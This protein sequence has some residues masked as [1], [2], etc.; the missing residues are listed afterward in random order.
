[1]SRKVLMIGLHFPP[2]GLR[3]GYARMMGFA[4]HL[5][6]F[7]WE[8]LILTA[9]PRAYRS[10]DPGSVG[11]IPGGC[12]V[13][14]AFA[15]DARRHLGIGGKYLSVCARPDSWISWWPAAV[16]CGLR[17]IRKHRIQAIWST[18]PVMTAHCVAHT[19]NRLT[20]LPW[21]AD[22][23]DPVA[24]SVAQRDARTIAMQMQWERRTL[25]RAACSVFTT[26]GTMR[27]YAEHYP[28]LADAGR[29]VVIENGFDEADFVGLPLHAPSTQTQPL[30]LVHAGGLYPE[31]R[32]PI[33]LFEAIAILRDEGTIRTDELR[34]T[35]RGSGAD[36]QYAP[37]LARLNLTGIVK[38]APTLPYGEALAEQA[39][40][41]GLLLF[42]GALFDRQIPSKV[43]EYFRLRRPM[44]AMVGEHGDTAALLRDMP[45]TFI[46]SE[47]VVPEIKE[48]LA[49]FVHAL[50]AE[51][52]SLRHLVDVEQ[53]S[54]RRSA[55][56]LSDHLNAVSGRREGAE[57]LQANVHDTCSPRLSRVDVPHGLGG[58]NG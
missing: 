26:A 41:D 2:S 36:R 8:P 19:L 45:G 35:L 30:Q 39:A 28:E 50:R 49:E 24:V 17:L 1:M 18:Y 25:A 12:R 10:R 55:E 57:A 54:R 27:D 34:V 53:Y 29:L 43:Y 38:L 15:L 22:F 51:A 44:F 20:G 13:Q 42:Q 11:A 48:R 7:D 37:E 14:R 16:L 3:V 21:I 40:A 4:R 47:G 58:R 5:P 32:S 9:S 56:K 33:P 6:D 31:G 23:R 46:A 52:P